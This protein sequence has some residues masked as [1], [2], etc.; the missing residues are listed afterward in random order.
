MILIT[1]LF[2][3]AVSVVMDD[4]VT[5]RDLAKTHPTNKDNKWEMQCDIDEFFYLFTR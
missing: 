5:G 1:S 4:I 2:T 3:Y